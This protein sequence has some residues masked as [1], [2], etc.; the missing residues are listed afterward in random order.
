MRRHPPRVQHSFQN[1][2]PQATAERL[3][4]LSLLDLTRS[5]ESKAE[6]QLYLE[7]Y[8]KHTVNRRTNW[9]SFARSYNYRVW[10]T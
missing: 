2:I 3:Q 6:I 4:R 8:L 1:A 9:I 7:L 10:D 5:V